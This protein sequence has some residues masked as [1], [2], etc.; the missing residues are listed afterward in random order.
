M[1]RRLFRFLGIM[2]KSVAPTNARIRS[3]E[4]V[5]YA[6][7][8]TI[9][10]LLVPRKD[11]RLGL[12]AAVHL[13]RLAG[14][15]G[16]LCAPADGWFPLDSSTERARLPRERL[17]SKWRSDRDLLL[18]GRASEV[19]MGREIGQLPRNDHWRVIP[20]TISRW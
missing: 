18:E 20:G 17:G 5:E 12:G 10:T 3:D 4:Q 7:P 14:A 6:S 15:V 8:K 2:P 9:G 1:R 19:A 11:L 13:G 16:L